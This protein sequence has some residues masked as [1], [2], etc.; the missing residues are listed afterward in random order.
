MILKYV[1]VWSVSCIQ[2]F[3]SKWCYNLDLWPWPAIG[4]F[5]MVT[6][7][8]KLYDPGVFGLVSINTACKVFLQ[9]MLQPRLLT[10]KNNSALPLMM[11]I[12]CTKLYDPR[13]CC[14]ASIL[15]IRFFS[16]YLVMLQQWPLTPN[17]EK[18]KGSSSHHDDQVYQVVWSWSLQFGLYRPDRQTGDAIP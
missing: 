4:C 16:K 17:P 1:M 13:V 6:K 14:S 2:D 8:T 3:D 7:H 12:K 9:V 18:Q 5:I 11:V 15:P 10:L